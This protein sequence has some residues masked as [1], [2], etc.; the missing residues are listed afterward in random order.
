[1][2]DNACPED[3]TSYKPKGQIDYCDTIALQVGHEARTRNKHRV[4]PLVE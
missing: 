1:M 3:A 2:S 4:G